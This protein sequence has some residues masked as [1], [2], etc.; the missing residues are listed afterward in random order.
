MSSCWSE[1]L[2]QH[3]LTCLGN[4]LSP[5]MTLLSPLLPKFW[6]Q[7][8]KLANC[9]PS[10]TFKHKNLI[11]YTNNWF[12]SH[13]FMY[14][15]FFLI[16]GINAYPVLITFWFW[17]YTWSYCKTNWTIFFTQQ[18]IY[19]TLCFNFYNFPIPKRVLS[20]RFNVNLKYDLHLC[21][22]TLYLFTL[23]HVSN[24]MLWIKFCSNTSLHIPRPWSS[25]NFV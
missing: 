25:S 21:Y 7:I 20:H 3:S 17:E 15:I 19:G 10:Q 8:E 22:A 12:L 14:A 4:F 16:H 1:I 11:E 6:N 24:F 23:C 9:K 5:C 2:K 13:L 18:P